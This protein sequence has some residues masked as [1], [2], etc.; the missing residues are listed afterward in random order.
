MWELRA[1]RHGQRRAVNK[2][3]ARFFAAVVTCQLP[4]AAS[5]QAAACCWRNGRAKERSGSSLPASPSS[6][7]SK[8][9]SSSPGF[10]A[11]TALQRCDDEQIDGARD[12]A[13]LLASRRGSRTWGGAAPGACVMSMAFVARSIGCGG[14]LE[15]DVRA[16][17]SRRTKTGTG[18]GFNGQGLARRDATK[19][20][21]SNLEVMTA[22]DGGVGAMRDNPRIGA[23]VLGADQE[24][25][26]VSRLVTMCSG[27][28]STMHGRMSN[29]VQDRNRA[30]RSMAARASVSGKR[31]SRR[32]YQVYSSN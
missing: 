2:E 13:R 22:P 30:R 17:V 7:L 29:L 19:S 14:L 1:P 18:L 12:A 15:M 24:P 8:L 27:R 10:L 4:A 20:W 16:A 9:R 3:G 5:L 11:S 28:R 6:P 31:N 21:G 23:A 32:R 25:V 26:E